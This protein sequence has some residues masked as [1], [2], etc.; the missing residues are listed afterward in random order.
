MEHNYVLLWLEAPL[1][2][3]GADSKFNRRDSLGF[4][5][6]SG[7]S[8]LIL[9]AMGAQGA[10]T[11]L[12]QALAPLRQTVVSFVRRVGHPPQLRTL[13]RE[14]MLEDFHMVGSGYDETDMWQSLHIPKK[15]DGAKAVGGGT[16]LTYRYFLQDAAF[17]VV[18][19]L[20][21]ALVATIVQG[22]QQPVYDM[23]LGRKC[24]VPSDIVYRGVFSDEASALQAALTIAHDKQR[25]E[26]FRVIDG[27]HEG[28]VIT[29]NDV[30]VQF[31]EQKKYRDRRVTVVQP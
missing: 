26:D 27:E 15:S 29:L 19:E 25:A 10:Q 28:E 4:P 24:C 21:E 6:K 2:S 18:V 22:L 9:C 5:T 20:P 17:A 12:L 11:E 13:E 7:V 31:G 8:G 23:Y 14:P 1:Q 30:A 3:W 16:K